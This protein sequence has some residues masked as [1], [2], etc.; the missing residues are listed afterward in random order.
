MELESQT[1][2]LSERLRKLSDQ[3]RD[4]ATM[5]RLDALPSSAQL[6][7]QLTTALVEI[8]EDKKYAGLAALITS[9]QEGDACYENLAPL[10]HAL[11][12]AAQSQTGFTNA[13]GLNESVR[14]LLAHNDYTPIRATLTYDF[15]VNEEKSLVFALGKE[16]EMYAVRVKSKNLIDECINDF[17]NVKRGTTDKINVLKYGGLIIVPIGGLASFVGGIIDFFAMIDHNNDKANLAHKIAERYYYIPPNYEIPLPATALTI[18]TTLFAG[19]ILLAYRAIKNRK[20]EIKEAQANV[21]F[22]SVNSGID[23][24]VA[25]FPLL[26]NPAIITET[27]EVKNANSTANQNK[28][29]VA[30]AQVVVSEINNR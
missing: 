17:N 26:D 4:Y 15:F 24:L 25:A 5:A 20:K 21:P 9:A 6:A 28:Q 30:Q 1:L 22:Q 27:E 14:Y 12:L 29:A 7:E 2:D 3:H 13:V 11:T 8:G 10:G 23:A 19:G 16:G 18:G